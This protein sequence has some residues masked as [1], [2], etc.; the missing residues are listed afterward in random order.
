MHTFD[1]PV[2]SMLHIACV[3]FKSVEIFC[4]I[5]LDFCLIQMLEAAPGKRFE[6]LYLLYIR[7]AHIGSKIEVKCRYCLTAVHFI[8]SCFER[9]A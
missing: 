3:S 4:L 1:S 7:T 8:L 5:V 6:S 9:N 2:Y